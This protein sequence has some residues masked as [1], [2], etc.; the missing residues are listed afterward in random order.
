MTTPP[1]LAGERL[2][3]SALNHMY[4]AADASNRSVTAATMTPISS[5]YAIDA[6]D[7]AVG[8]TYRL[9]CWGVGAQ[10]SSAQTL[11]FRANTIAGSGL[12]LVTIANSFCAT[13]AQ[14]RWFAR[15]TTTCAATGSGGTITGFLEGLVIQTGVTTPSIQFNSEWT[16]S[17]INTA[18]NWGI[19]IDCEWGS[20][21]G[22]PS[23]TCNGTLFER[24]G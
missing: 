6:F 5:Q 17:A 15:M 9:S 14:F 21:T 24:L 7:A 2:T 12:N 16:G 22:T 23:I 13:T 3:A 19:E 8:T 11:S 20:V 10:G 1:F 4:A 18:T